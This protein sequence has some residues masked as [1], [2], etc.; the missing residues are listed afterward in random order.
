MTPLEKLK[1]CHDSIKEKIPFKP[2]IAIILGSGLG[3]L[4]D[5]IDTAAV[6]DYSEID[7]FPQSTVIGHKGQFVFG[8]IGENPVVIMQGRVHFYEGYCMSDV[9]LPVRLMKLMGAEIL[10][11]T[12]AAGG[13]DPAMKAGDFMLITDQIS[14]FTPNPLIGENFADLGTR[15]PDMSEIYNKDLCRIVQETAKEQGIKLHEGVY[16]QATGPSFE[17]PAEIKM[18]RALGANA[19]GMSTACEAIVANHAGMK[20]CGISFIA[21]LACGMTDNPLTHAEVMEA[22]TEGAPR[23]KNLIRSAVEK[24]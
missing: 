12:N 23:F 15:F 7:G 11:L 21:N 4:A 2:K 14:N 20:I 5:E 8:R 13:I 9:V 6:I 16:V 19:V 18:F 1:K 24:M 22:A 17:S 10:L 3:A